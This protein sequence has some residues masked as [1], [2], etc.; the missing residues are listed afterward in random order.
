MTARLDAAIPPSQESR[1]AEQAPL[2]VSG[3]ERRRPEGFIAQTKLVWANTTPPEVGNDAEEYR[4]DQTIS[5][6]R[7][8]SLGASLTKRRPLPR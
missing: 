3:T 6:R 1:R 7:S 4:A 8:S 5:R 2:F